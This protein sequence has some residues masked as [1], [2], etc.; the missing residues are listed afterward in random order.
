VTLD[1]RRDSIRCVTCSDEAVAMQ[2]LES[3]AGGLATCID[4]EGRPVEVMT[5]LVGVVS[6]GQV[7]LVHAGV[8]LTVIEGPKDVR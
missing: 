5:D 4:E 1:A 8:A 2:V 6:S 7:V 3:G